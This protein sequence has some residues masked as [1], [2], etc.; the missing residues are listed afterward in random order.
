[1]KLRPTERF[2]KD[3]ERLPPQFQR[4]VDKA[5]ELLLQNPRHPSLQIKKL[6]GYE[7]RW[8]GRVTLHYR[9]T[10]TLEGDTCILLRVGTHDLLR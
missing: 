7:T 4:R 5:L 8:E 6:K 1:M 9:F 2:C 10:F 3:Y